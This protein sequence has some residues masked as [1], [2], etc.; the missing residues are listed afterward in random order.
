MSL[1]QG[2][3]RGWYQWRYGSFNRYTPDHYAV[4]YLTVAGMRV[5][6]DDPL[7]M[8]R[9]FQSVTTRPLR[10]GNLQ[11]TMRECS[12][13]SFR[14]TWNEILDRQHEIWAREDSLRAP[15]TPETPRCSIPPS[16]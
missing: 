12:G 4:G 14:D 15:F 3:R 16:W 13:K 7:F 10:F 1:D 2:D 11:R 8:K 6:Y 5:F 9:Y